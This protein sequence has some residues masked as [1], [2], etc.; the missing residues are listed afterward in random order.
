[1][2]MLNVGTP[3][4]WAQLCREMEELFRPANQKDW[5]RKKPREFKQG[6]LPID[7]WIIKFQTYSQSAQLNSGQLIDIIEQNID[8]SIIRKIIEDDTRPTDL[9]DY[10]NKV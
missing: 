10:L 7:E 9:T 5:A 8:P 1:M 4:T 2:E 3:Y 6:C